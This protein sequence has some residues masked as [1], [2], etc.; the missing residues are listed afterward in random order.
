MELRRKDGPSRDY[1]TPG[2]HPIISH[3]TQTLL[4]MPARFRRQDP[5]RAVAC[6]VMPNT[7]MGSA[8]SPDSCKEPDRI[9]HGILRPLVSGTQ[10]LL[11]TNLTGPETALTKEADNLA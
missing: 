11:Q 4:H 10:R 9:P 3:Q 5:D 6:E 7:E 2:I 8:E 1:P